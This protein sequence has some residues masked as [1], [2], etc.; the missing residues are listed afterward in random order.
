MSWINWNGFLRGLLWILSQIDN[1]KSLKRNLE[2]WGIWDSFES[3]IFAVSLIIK[4]FVGI[5]VF[6]TTEIWKTHHK[7]NKILEKS[8]KVP[9]SRAKQFT[10]EHVFFFFCA[11]YSY[12]PKEFKNVIKNEKCQNFF[13]SGMPHICGLF[14]PDCHVTPHIFFRN[15]WQTRYVVAF[16]QHFVKN[17]NQDKGWLMQSFQS[18]RQ[19]KISLNIP[20]TRKFCFQVW[21]LIHKIELFKIFD[22]GNH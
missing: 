2:K 15:Q 5:V 13:P 1:F 20:K 12:C 8:S 18:N 17:S 3:L 21:L 10:S 11:M 6:V 7:T 22:K 16:C 4:V 9:N 14:N 19:K